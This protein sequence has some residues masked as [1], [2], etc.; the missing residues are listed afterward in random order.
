M[1]TNFFAVCSSSH[2]QVSV[3]RDETRQK[4]GGTT[5]ITNERNV[6]IEYI[7]GQEDDRKKEVRNSGKER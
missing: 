7:T 5:R 2:A 6:Q 3:L 4:T 1:E